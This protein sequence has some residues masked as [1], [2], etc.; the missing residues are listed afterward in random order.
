M[1][2]IDVKLLT[3]YYSEINDQI[4]KVNAIMKYYLR[5]F[6]N[7]MQNDQAKWLF[8]VEFIINNASSLITL[9]SFFL[10]NLSQNS[11]LNFKLFES[12][13]ENFMFQAQDKLINVKKFIKKMKKLIKHLHNEMLI[14]QIIY[15]SHV[16][17][18]HHSCSRYFVEDEVWLNACNLSIIYFIIKLNDHNVNFF[19][20][21]HV[22]KNNFLIIELNLSIF[23][24]IYLVFHVIL[25]N[26]ITNDF[27]SNQYQKLQ[28]LVVVKNDKRFWYVN[29][30]LNFK[31]DRCYNSSLLKYYIDWKDHFST[32]KS[33]NLLNNCK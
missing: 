18:S 9:A 11:C 29:S 5:V 4:E 25:L 26:H 22:F 2:K 28:K 8:K 20:I 32:W 30:I 23:M 24:K 10:I 21:K 27:L 7:Y 1:L 12:L 13:F 16:N 3:T 31:H 17:L 33:F 19:K 14:T 6:I 15:K